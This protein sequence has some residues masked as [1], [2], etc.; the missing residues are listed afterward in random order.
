MR[1]NRTARGVL[2]VHTFRLALKKKS[3]VVTLDCIGEDGRHYQI[4]RSIAGRFT[5]PAAPDP[6]ESLRAFQSAF[7]KNFPGAN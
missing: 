5:V 1:R 6:A 3:L 4:A 2:A 7:R